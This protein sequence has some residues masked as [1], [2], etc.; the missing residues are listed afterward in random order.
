MKIDSD[1]RAALRSA[2]NQQKYVDRDYAAKE[3]A[4]KAALTDL[5]T[6]KPAIERNVKTAKRWLKLA[7]ELNRKAHFV[8][9]NLGLDYRGDR[10]AHDERF[11]AAGGVPPKCAA[12]WN[13]DAMMHRLSL[14]T[15]KEGAA[16]I[17]AIGI[18][19][20]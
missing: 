19:W 10:M 17:K 8:F 20:V 13:F 11:K 4:K 3:R 18:N 7:E 6:R 5:F 14:A 9:E 15:P 16:I 12:R 1:L 2:Y